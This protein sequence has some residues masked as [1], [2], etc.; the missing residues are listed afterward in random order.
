MRAG[1]EMQSSALEGYWAALQQDPDAVPSATLDPG[2]ARTARRLTALI[3]PMPEG[4]F[5]E[6]L[7]LRLQAQAATGPGDS[8]PRPM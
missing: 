6:Q 4:P 2:L 8:V 7:G 5:V 3:P 1:K